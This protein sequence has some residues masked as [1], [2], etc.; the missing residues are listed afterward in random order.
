MI[1]KKQLITNTQDCLDV[2]LD[3]NIKTLIELTE[4]YEKE[5]SFKISII[6]KITY[7]IKFF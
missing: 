7:V 1:L 2:E 3:N 4:T 5:N 6:S